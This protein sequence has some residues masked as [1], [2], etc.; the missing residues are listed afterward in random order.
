MRAADLFLL[1]VGGRRAILACTDAAKGWRGQVLGL[2]LVLTGSLARNYD[3]TDL[4]QEWT[5]LLHGV[6]ISIGNSLILFTL[7]FFAA[8]IRT[9][10]RPTFFGGFR[11]FLTLFWMTAPMAWLYAVPYEHFMGPVEAIR[12]N[13]W[14]LVLVSVWRVALIT[15]ILCV[16][17]GA[18]AVP[19]LCMVLA[20]SVWVT[21]AG[22]QLSPQPLVDFMGGLRMTEAEEAIRSINTSV[23]MWSFLLSL[24]MLIVYILAARSFRGGWFERDVLLRPAGRVKVSAWAVPGCVVLAFVPLLARFQP[25]QRLRVVAERELMEGRVAE[26]LREMSAHARSEYPPHWDPPPSYASDVGMSRWMPEVRRALAEGGQADWV[27]AMYMEK[28]WRW[29]CQELHLPEVAM[30]GEVRFTTLLG[31][32]SLY[33]DEPGVHDAVRFHFEHDERMGDTDRGVLK[34]LLG[35]A[36]RE[37]AK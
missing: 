2:L 23:L 24:P 33:V 16:L 26:A 14:T 31:H 32:A 17:W 15:R 10:R 18:R 7:V 29:V 5:T 3:G 1:L 25:E 37:Q 12:A 4:L 36:Y 9:Q 8:W 21:F 22:T 35:A 28:S 19:V 11:V 13:G 27:R 6:G 34:E 30:P 20:F